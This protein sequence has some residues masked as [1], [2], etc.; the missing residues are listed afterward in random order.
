V[1]DSGKVLVDDDRRNFD[2][3]TLSLVAKLENGHTR[4]LDKWLMDNFGAPLGFTLRPIGSS[5]VVAESQ[6]ADVHPGDSARAINGQTFE[7]F[8]HNVAKYI[9]KSSER[10][11]RF[12]L[13]YCP[14]LRLRPNPPIA[15]APAGNFPA[16][17]NAR[18]RR[19]CR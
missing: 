10:E 13:V 16:H 11:A 17:P 14:Y 1:N 9:A 2:T 7:D 18:R 8:F 12:A 6:I 4:F 15:S 5:W 3:A 19:T